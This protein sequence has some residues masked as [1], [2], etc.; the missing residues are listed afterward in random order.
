MLPG[1]DSRVGVPY[2]SE[3][4]VGGMNGRNQM[5]EELGGVTYDCSHGQAETKMWPGGGHANK[6]G[7]Q[8]EISMIGRESAGAVLGMGLLDVN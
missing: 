2:R 5:K 6:A 1:G 4:P 8:G 7:W 3:E